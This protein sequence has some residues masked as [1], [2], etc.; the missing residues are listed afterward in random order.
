M[1]MNKLETARAYMQQKHEA[2]VA[3]GLRIQKKM[4][5]GEYPVEDAPCFCG[6]RN[7]KVVGHTE[8]YGIPAQQ[9]IC[10]E[11]ALVRLNPRMTKEAYGAFYNNEYR[12]LNFPAYL[13]CDMTTPEEEQA[14]LYERQLIKGEALLTRAVEQAIP[15][16][17]VVVD[18]GCHL[19][20]TLVPFAKTYGSEVWGIEID[21]DAAEFARAN[22][23]NVVSTIEEL[24][25]KGVK[26]DL[27]ILQD[28]IEHF[29][30]LNELKQI[31]QIMHRDSYLYVYTPGMF[32][33]NF[34]GNKQI[35]HT[36][37]FCANTLNWAM[38][39]LGFDPTFIDEE[40]HSFWQWRPNLPK[41][42]KPVEW[43]EYQ[44]DEIE[45]REYRKMPPFTGVCKF[46]KDTLYKNI[47]EVFAM[48]HPDL[49]DLTDT[50][51]GGVALIG[52]GPS[53]N[54]EVQ[55]IRDLQQQGVKVMSILR[56]YPWCVD[57][58]ITPDFVVSLD[59]TDDQAKGFARTVPGVKYLFASVTNPSFFDYIKGEK[60]YIFDSRDD[61]KIQ[62]FRR[63]A[64]YRHCSV[65]NGGGSVVICSMSLAFNLGFTDLHCFG[66]DFMFPSAQHTHAEGIAGTNIVNHV[67]PV[68]IDGEEILTTS[69]FLLF[70][71]QALDMVSVAHAEGVLKS[72]RFYG[73][74]L[75]NKL[76]DGKWTEEAA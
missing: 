54:K 65:V 23:I 35:A 4:E 1:E 6:A 11:C 3:C 20:G 56:M 32:R 72:V 22:G 19:G 74:S 33:V 36:Y 34:H 16:P 55:T 44:V 75:V 60:V 39:A 53:I 10:N 61:R 26:A 43:V 9:V 8:R 31:G 40:C 52:G 46:T 28:V 63:K 49:L 14:A 5:S 7:D 25:E 27:V 58:G 37:Y 76:W 29:T 13:T 42:R 12:E 45:G 21:T 17:K 71:N 64:G 73:E 30:D 59:C 18:Y 70:A 69:A 62:D 48:H 41:V 2:S 51:S 38:V 47:E 67:M 50:Q 57:N 24:I 68:I 66:M 15:A